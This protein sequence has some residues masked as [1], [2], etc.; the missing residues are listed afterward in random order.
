MDPNKLTVPKLATQWRS[1]FTSSN[2]TSNNSCKSILN[3]KY[4]P[5]RGKHIFLAT[6]STFI[7]FWWKTCHSFFNL[8]FERFFFIDFVLK[9]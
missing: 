2:L 6:E 9:K 1:T 7:T 3:F 8:S 5:K 4:T